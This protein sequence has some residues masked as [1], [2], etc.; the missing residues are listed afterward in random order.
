[1]HSLSRRIVPQNGFCGKHK[2]LFLSGILYSMKN[3]PTSDTPVCVAIIICNEIIEDKRTSNKTL[4]SLFNSI[5]VT[6]LPAMHPRLFFFASVTHVK[7]DQP[8]SF[9]ITSPSGKE[10][11]RADGAVSSGGDPALII[12]LTLEVLGLTVGEEGIHLLNVVSGEKML[13]S[14]SFSVVMQK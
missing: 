11:L 6:A 1:M 13:G 10:I 5:S 14:R 9:T 12:D 8:L 4:V 7:D 3:T 2:T